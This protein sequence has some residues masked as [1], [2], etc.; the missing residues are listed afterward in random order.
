VGGKGRWNAAEA[1]GISSVVRS[2]INHVA[3]L[4]VDERES[5]MEMRGERK[6]SYRRTGR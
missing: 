4:A 6:T 2:R 1:K 3:A 5:G